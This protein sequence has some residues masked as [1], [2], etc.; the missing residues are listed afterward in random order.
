MA[1]YLVQHGISLA[2]DIDPERGLSDEG[3]WEKR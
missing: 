1:I 3:A 2:K